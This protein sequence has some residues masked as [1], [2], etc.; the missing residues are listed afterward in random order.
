MY[1]FTSVLKNPD[2]ATIIL[3]FLRRHRAKAGNVLL[4]F[5]GLAFS[6]DV[7]FNPK[8]VQYNRIEAQFNLYPAR[9][10]KGKK[11]AHVGIFNASNNNY[12]SLD[13]TLS[14]SASKSV[15]VL[16]VVPVPFDENY[17]SG[18]DRHHLF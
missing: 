11:P 7:V 1:S 17:T 15:L 14:D 9:Y 4:A 5:P 12:Q 3:R 10:H 6:F 18:K 16:A 8:K 13:V 2:I